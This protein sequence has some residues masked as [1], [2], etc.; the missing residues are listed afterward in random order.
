M[1]RDE[2]GLDT[3]CHIPDELRKKITWRKPAEVQQEARKARD[4][5]QIELLASRGVVSGIEIEMYEAAKKDGAVF[6]KYGKLAGGG[7]AGK[8]QEQGSYMTEFSDLIRECLRSGAMAVNKRNPANGRALLHQAGTD[9]NKP[10]IKMLLHEFGAD[11]NVRS[12]MGGDTPLHAAAAAGARACVF[13]L[14]TAG[15]TVQATNRL[16]QT[17]LHFAATPNTARV[18]LEWGANIWAKDKLGRSCLNTIIEDGHEETAQYLGGIA[19]ALLIEQ[20]TGARQQKVLASHQKMLDAEALEEAKAGVAEGEALSTSEVLAKSLLLEYQEWRRG[21]HKE[22]VGERKE[23]SLAVKRVETRER[24]NIFKAKLPG[25]Y[26]PSQS[27]KSRGR[28]HGFS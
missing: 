6:K 22:V 24:L 10:L 7:G 18:L 3:G 12:F 27:S 28:R 2:V 8:A 11:A 26:I 9:G 20:A 19:E 13:M 5:K 1:P 17:P 25:Q 23:K 16:R 15:A 4:K 21:E 14:I